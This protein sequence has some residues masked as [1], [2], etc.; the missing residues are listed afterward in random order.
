MSRRNTSTSSPGTAFETDKSEFIGYFVRKTILITLKDISRFEE[1]LSAAL[2]SGVNYVHGIEFRTTELRK[3]RDQARALAIQAAK[4][5]ATALAEGLG[6]KLGRPRDIREDHA[7]WWSSYD[8]WWGQRWGSAQAQNV[9]QNAGPSS[10]GMEGSVAPGQIS[11]QASV[12][13]VFELQ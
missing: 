8:S 6:E 4:E 9:I 5:K 3:Y 7:G 13:V 12:T 11:V 2:E 10:A 1:L